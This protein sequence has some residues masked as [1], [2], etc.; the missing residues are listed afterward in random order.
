M[1][2]RTSNIAPRILDAAI[3]LFS[4]FGYYG[5]TTRDIAKK[6]GV[7]EG[8]IYRLFESKQNLFNTAVTTVQKNA[9]DPGAFLMLLFEKQKDTRRDFTTI[10]T[11]VIQKW[12]ESLSQKSARLLTQAYFADPK[13]H[14]LAYA[15]IDKIVEI[16][17]ATLQRERKIKDGELVAQALI[18]TLLHFKITYATELSVKDES[19]Q[20]NAYIERW[21]RVAESRQSAG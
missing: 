17:A 10:V 3:S 21:L 8:S 16:L 7:T 18:F 13:W 6:A 12:Y 9:L 4:D 14:K 11:S 19:A 2:P 5:V 20:V 15:P 1:T